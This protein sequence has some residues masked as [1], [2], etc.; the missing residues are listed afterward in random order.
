MNHHAHRGVDEMVHQLGMQARKSHRQQQ[1]PDELMKQLEF[2]TKKP[3]KSVKPPGPLK[4]RDYI[5]SGG[6][7]INRSPYTIHKKY[8]YSSE[9][10]DHSSTTSCTAPEAAGESVNLIVSFLHVLVCA[11]M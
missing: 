1:S 10:R 8:I 11:C 6:I 9:H 2:A 3:R 5:Y 4:P 7:K